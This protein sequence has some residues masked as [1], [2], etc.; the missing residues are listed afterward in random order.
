MP[1]VQLP[2]D[3]MTTFTNDPLDLVSV[4]PVGLLSAHATVTCYCTNFN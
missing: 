4:D 3:L 2:L 1:T